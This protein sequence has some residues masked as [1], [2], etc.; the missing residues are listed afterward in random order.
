M[1]RLQKTMVLCQKSVKIDEYFVTIITSFLFGIYYSS[2]R[3]AK[4]K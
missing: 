1:K 2:D 4:W 3:G